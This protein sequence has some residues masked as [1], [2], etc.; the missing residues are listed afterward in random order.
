MSGTLE[1]LF[2]AFPY[3]WLAVR[4]YLIKSP[5]C[6]VVSNKLFHSML[7]SCADRAERCVVFYMRVW[8]VKWSC[9]VT[10]GWL[11]RESGEKQNC[12][13]ASLSE[14]GR[15]GVGDCKE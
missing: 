6:Q 8:V 15:R 7:P 10:T 12:S 13:T 1:M 4:V 9:S 11:E 3:T 2:P 14:P 5:R